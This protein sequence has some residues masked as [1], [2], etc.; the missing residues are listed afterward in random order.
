VKHWQIVS[1]SVYHRHRLRLA[2]DRFISLPATGTDNN[3]NVAQV[4]RPTVGSILTLRNTPTIAAL[5]PQSR[6]A[7][8]SMF[9]QM[10]T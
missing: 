3:G 7:M 6:Q 10:L 4:S 2:S 9:P 8:L 1:T 5:M